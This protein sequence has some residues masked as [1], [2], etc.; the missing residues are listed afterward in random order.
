MSDE[1]RLKALTA[2]GP[3]RPGLVKAVST[4][5]HRAGANIEDSR[6]SILGSEFALVML[7]SGSASEVEAA[8]NACEALGRELGLKFLF[9]DTRRA[10]AGG[11]VV[12]RLRVSGL[13]HPGI[14]ESVTSALEKRGINLA[15]LSTHIAHLPLTGTPMFVLDAELQI[16]AKTSLAEL[17]RELSEMCERENL[18]LSLEPRV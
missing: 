2:I 3:D 16:P 10:E 17:R 14:V 6:M 15:S 5:V 1:R 18:D 12:F 4:A 7:Y 13:D 9:Q 11:F 8:E